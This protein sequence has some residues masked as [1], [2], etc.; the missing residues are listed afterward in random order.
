MLW[1]AW[2]CVAKEQFV[3]VAMPLRKR[4]GS[5]S[6]LGGGGENV[7][8]HSAGANPC[9]PAQRPGVVQRRRGADHSRPGPIDCPQGWAGTSFGRL[10]EQR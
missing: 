8:H 10:G 4:A 5:H 7:T 3:Q 2:G 1:S 9:G 6:N